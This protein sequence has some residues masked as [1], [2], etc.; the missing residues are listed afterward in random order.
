M[1]DQEEQEVYQHQYSEWVTDTLDDVSRTFALSLQFLDDPLR[2]YV[3]NAYLL[4]R[5]SDTIED[6]T[7]L[8]SKQKSNLLSDFNDVIN[9]GLPV[10]KF[11]RNVELTL[12]MDK[13]DISNIDP[14][15]KLVMEAEKSLELFESFDEDIQEAI[16]PW[17]SELTEGMKIFVNRYSKKN[18]IRI[19]NMEELEEYCY[20]V[21]G[22]VGRMI[23]DILAV[24]YDVETEESLHTKAENY[25]L[26]LQM[27]N[28]C[29]DVYDDY[30]EEDN[31]YLPLE[32]L[33][34]YGASHSGVTKTENSHAVGRAVIELTRKCESHRPAA[35]TCLNWIEG[36][37]DNGEFA[38]LSLPYLL[39]IA[40][41]RE[42]QANFELS[43]ES[44]EVKIARKEVMEIA[45]SLTAGPE[46]TLDEYEEKI[47]NGEFKPDQ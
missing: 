20:Y 22:T 28:I 3:S 42:L 31:V 26:F 33:E 25:G 19:Q 38:A 4:C 6:T 2:T 16:R 17:V 45:A 30:T 27:V 24:M 5:I 32:L 23:T 46:Y 10:E 43:V 36:V 13:E 1:S 8:T 21:A 9:G 40:T 34:E 47:L 29:K 37:T 12:E 7:R 44:K 35:K 39:A 41:I 11:Q 14:D 15:W 18:G